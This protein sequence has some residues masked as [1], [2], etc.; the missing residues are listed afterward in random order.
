MNQEEP[1]IPSGGYSTPENY[2]GMSLVWRDEFEGHTLNPSDWKH[3]TGGSGWG[4]NEL[5]YYQEKNTAVHDGYLIITAEKENVG[6]KN[7]TSSRIIT[8]GK[9]EFQYGRVDIRALLPKGQGI[10]PAL[11]ML[12]ANVTTVGWPACGEIDIMEMI[13]GVEK[14]I[15][16]M[17]LHIGITGEAMLLMAENFRLPILKSSQMNFTFFQLYGLPQRSHGI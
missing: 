9:K 15:P 3:E 5:E 17:A 8:Q 12:G 11:W 10:W 13:G 2:S 16:S 14:I 7:Y 1:K 6:G 4:N